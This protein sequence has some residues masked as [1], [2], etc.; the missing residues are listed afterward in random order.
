MAERPRA[1]EL[2]MICF[3]WGGFP[4]YAARLVGAFAGTS[5]Q[6]IAVE[7]ATQRFAAVVRGIV[8]V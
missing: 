4:Q 6:K 2:H 8:H 5:A 1:G 7:N 3:A